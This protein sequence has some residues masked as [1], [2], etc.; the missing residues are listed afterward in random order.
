MKKYILLLFW[1][2]TCTLNAQEIK[3]DV[4]YTPQDQDNWCVAASAQCVLN[5]NKINKA[6]CDIMD[7]VRLLPNSEHGAF[8]CCLPMSGGLDHPCYKGVKLGY[9]NEKGSAKGILMH[10][11]TLPSD[12]MPW[13]ESIDEIR[14]NLTLKRPQIIHLVNYKGIPNHAVVICGIDDSNNIQIMDPYDKYGLDW[15]SYFDLYSV[16][17]GGGTLVPKTCLRG[18]YPCHCYNLEYDPHL[19]EEGIDCGPPCP[20]PCPPPPPP[21]PPPPLGDC[22]DCLKNGYEKEIDCGGP[23]CPPC[24]D[25]PEEIIIENTLYQQ[26]NEIRATKKITAKGT[27]VETGQNRKVSFITEETGSIVLLPGFRVMRGSNFSA[28]TEDL[29][30]YSRICP[31]TLCATVWAN[32]IVEVPPPNHYNN[33]LILRD[34]LYAVKIEYKIYGGGELIYDDTLKITRNGSFELWKP[35][36][37]QGVAY[38][39]LFYSVFYCNGD[40]HS[41]THP[42]VVTNNGRK[43]SNTDP[44]E[45]DPLPQFSPP[46]P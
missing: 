41:F 6:Q 45:A 37:P 30:K 29:S 44:E 42:F 9:H 15:I 26:S 21:P 14:A 36:I 13:P 24:Q 31:D 43:S 22:T 46:P 2:L 16:W 27:S 5:Y 10:F 4:A 8:P 17:V 20:L 39:T 38:Y 19:G 33:A 3:L 32:P 40:R 28:R 1:G 7:Y 34:L 12:V 25:L 35:F 11:G 23:D 18:D